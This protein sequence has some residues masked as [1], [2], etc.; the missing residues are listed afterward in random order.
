MR[1]ARLSRQITLSMSV[2][3]TIAVLMVFV[4]TFIFYAIYLTLSPPPP[5]PPPLLPEAP[6]FV[7]FA[8]F[9]L[10]GLAVA[11]HAALRL[12]RRILAPLNSLAESARKIAAGDLFARADPGD[13]TLG[14]TARLAD[15]F[16]AMAQRLQDMSAAMASRNAAIAHELRTPL[17]ILR[18][19]LQGVADGVFAPDDRMLKTCLSQVEGL[20]RLVDDLRIVT[21]SESRRLEMRFESTNFAAE[22]CSA[23][24]AMR[25]ALAEAGFSIETEIEP[26][27]LR[28]DGLRLRQALV[29]LLENARRYATPGWIRIVTRREQTSLV[30][31][32]QDEGPGLSAEFAPH[33]FEIFSREESSR[34]RRFGGSGLGLSVV[35]AIA[36]AHGGRAQYRTSPAGGS[37]F[38][39][40]LL[41]EDAGAA[42][43]HMS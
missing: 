35:R 25:P 24:D 31:S 4:G 32:V 17:T 15:D 43:S 30:L 28:C 38:E 40:A 2:V 6:D 12:T 19:N 1:Q 42:A 7:L 33:A 10:V 41:C 29:A 5:G 39:I 26:V 22:V 27:L 9:L 3:A 21:L 13:R 18:G 37:I 8:V 36:E 16:N 11:I 20:S 34:S 23:L 14:E